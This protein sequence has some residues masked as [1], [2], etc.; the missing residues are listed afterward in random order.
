MLSHHDLL[1]VLPDVN[2]AGMGQE[3]DR[4]KPPYEVLPP[5]FTE[6][7]YR[8]QGDGKWP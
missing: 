5:L 1:A 4:D 8:L 7:W 3:Y 2:Q 6:W